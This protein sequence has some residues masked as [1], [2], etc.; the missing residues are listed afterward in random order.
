MFLFVS[1]AFVLPLSWFQLYE[2]FSVLR[3]LGAIAQVHAENGDIIDEVTEQK[4]ESWCFTV[5][6]VK[7]VQT[8]DE[9]NANSNC[10]CH[11]VTVDVICK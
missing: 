11:E 4:T 1:F 2:A 9:R 3:D 8:K 6:S 10:L 7:L 5:E